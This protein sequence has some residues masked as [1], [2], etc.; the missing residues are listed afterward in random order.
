MKNP[1]KPEVN[2]ELIIDLGTIL[3]GFFVSSDISAAASKPVRHQAPNKID[4]AKDSKP[5]FEELALFV[6]FEIVKS[7]HPFV[8]KK[9]SIRIKRIT[10][11]IS[12]ITPILFM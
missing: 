6:I 2:K 12:V 10:P 3:V 4:K 8:T 7:S 5:M 11:I 1:K 9:P